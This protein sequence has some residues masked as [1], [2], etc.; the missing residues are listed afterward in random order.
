MCVQ[1]ISKIHIHVQYK[2]EG[3][4]PWRESKAAGIVCNISLRLDLIFSAIRLFTKQWKIYI[5]TG[6]TAL[7]RLEILLLPGKNSRNTCL[8]L[9]ISLRN[10][11]TEEQFQLRPQ[12]SILRL[13]T[14]ERRYVVFAEW[15]LKP[16]LRIFRPMATDKPCVF[17]VQ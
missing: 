7:L 4:H 17:T 6:V 12:Y 11:Y 10:I 14:T 15:R 16:V 3:S 1:Y 8:L 9:N 5:S 2:E 13:S